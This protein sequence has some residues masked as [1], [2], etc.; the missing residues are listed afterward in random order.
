MGTP[1]STCFTDT[2]PPPV[3]ST[4]CWTL[5]TATTLTRMISSCGARRSPQVP[6]GSTT[7]KCWQKELLPRKSTLRLS[8]RTSRRSSTE[9]PTMLELALDWKELSSSSATFTTSAS[10]RCSLAIP[11][12]SLPEETRIFNTI[13]STTYSTGKKKK[14]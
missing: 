13:S 12:D 10:A 5:P 7:L 8:Q 6:R 2:P 1:T 11:R 4:P 14:K 9:H 3:P